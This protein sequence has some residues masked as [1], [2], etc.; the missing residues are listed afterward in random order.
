MYIYVGII[1]SILFVIINYMLSDYDVFNPACLYSAMNLACTIMCL[2][3]KNEYAIE[4][5][6]NTIAVLFVG[7]LAFT[8]TN[9]LT[10]KIR[11][12]GQTSICF[13]FQYIYIE[14]IW[15]V[16]F[17]IL[18]ALVAYFT[19]KYVVSVSTKI[20][21]SATSISEHIGNYNHA[22]KFMTEQFSNS[23]VSQ[24][25]VMKVG[26]PICN[27]F[28]YVLIVIE[29]NN[30]Q[31]KKKLDKII[32]I[33]I[34]VTIIIS[35]FTG[36]RSAAFR[37]IT[38]LIAGRIIILR[39]ANGSYK[40]GNVKI[41]FKV[42]FII[43]LVAVLTL[44][45]RALIG[46]STTFDATWYR[47]IFPYFGSP[48][49][50]LDMYLNN[51]IQYHSTVFGEQTFYHLLT[52]I[53]NHLNIDSLK[54]I[55]LHLPFLTSNGISTGNVYTMYYM[56]IEDFGYLGVPILSFMVAWYYCDSYSK[57]MRLYSR[58]KVINFRF[59]LYIYMFNSLVMLTFSNRFYEHMF[60]VS[61]WKM[62]I[63]VSIMWK[64]VEK[65]WLS[66]RIKFAGKHI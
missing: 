48:I 54:N 10:R 59:F 12:K 21:G 38:A 41:L 49:V 17:L 29:L 3:L 4:L 20:F 8:T 26:T 52:Y 31:A 56:F 61:I 28:T 43:I 25:I 24:N 39:R 55:A 63:L 66:G 23:G 42:L 64:F 30:Y 53:G 35:V 37:Y 46:R 51:D 9:I 62:L 45:T 5:H 16:I 2:L 22:I 1:I 15:I 40:K 6:G 18:E 7:L 27:A 47:A 11:K 44:E 65:G 13:K 58:K 33:A 32:V 14:S 19:L 34:I 36:S 57:L 60:N 50:N